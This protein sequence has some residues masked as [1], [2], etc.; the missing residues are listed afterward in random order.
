MSIRKKLIFSLLL[1]S[2]LGASLGAI[3]VWSNRQLI[4][5][6]TFSEKHLRSAIDLSIK[7]GS[8]VKQTEGYLFLY[9]MFDD[10]NELIKFY[11]SNYL[12]DEQLQTISSNLDLVEAK[13]LIE[14]LQ[15]DN[16]R[17][18]AKAKRLIDLYNQ[19][20]KSKKGSS[21][22][23][24]S[25]PIFAVHDVTYQ[26]SSRSIKLAQLLTDFINKQIENTAAI[27]VSQ[28]SMGAE[29]H[30]L[31]YLM[32][33][34][35]VSRELFFSGIDTVARQ[36]DLLKRHSKDPEGR[37]LVEAMQHNKNELKKKGQTLLKQYAGKFPETTDISGEYRESIKEFNDLAAQLRSSGIALDNMRTK[38]AIEPRQ[39]ILR[40]AR[41][42]NY[43][44]FVIISVVFL[45]AILLALWLTMGLSRSLKT[46]QLAAREVGAGNLDIVVD[47]KSKDDLGPLAATFNQMISDLKRTR[48][49]LN[50]RNRVLHEE[51]SKRKR[52]EKE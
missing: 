33:D 40:K 26:M 6:L 44:V 17:F 20:S 31:L 4:N 14:G 15:A 29:E 7:I 22:A 16:E 49:T 47:I 1:I 18:L 13:Q 46:L 12:I 19:K 30:L 50:E 23:K 35:V 10:I 39:K 34:D 48:E 27:N 2:L 42:F 45:L 21:L 37:R 51:I 25:E 36:I 28:D 9:L 8:E 41:A 11:Q 5:E 24:L 38:K 3:A 43:S 52:I 32:I